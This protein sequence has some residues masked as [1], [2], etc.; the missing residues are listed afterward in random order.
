MC[1]FVYIYMLVEEY[2]EKLWITK[3]FLKNESFKIPLQCK[4]LTTLKLYIS[5]YIITNTKEDLLK[6][7][8]TSK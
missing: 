8:E 3:V 1:V 7:K 2:L 5:I 6:E 4:W